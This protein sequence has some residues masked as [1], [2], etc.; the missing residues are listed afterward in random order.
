MT[1]TAIAFQRP[2]W[3]T[4]SRSR[5]ALAEHQAAIDAVEQGAL[6][7]KSAMDRAQA[8]V[9]EAEAA[10]RAADAEIAEINKAELAELVENARSGAPVSPKTQRT[11]ATA[12]ARAAECRRRV[13]VARQV[14][15]EVAVPFDEARSASLAMQ[16]Q[17]GQLACAVLAELHSDA[18]SRM[19]R[20][21]EEFVQAEIDVRSI[22]N[23]I[24]QEGRKLQ[25]SGR[26]GTPYY[27]AGAPLTQ[28]FADEPAYEGPRMPQLYRGEA[29]WSQFLL[30]LLGDADALP[31]EP[32]PRP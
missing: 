30:A 17:L 26:D 24:A 28:A 11:R 23:A 5:R 14:L 13:D 15:A 16:A 18:M 21:R 4:A 8:A 29:R 12:E 22:S 19:R 20:A 2:D 7:V 25:D 31:P 1:A 9:R 10:V 27:R 3:M 6:E 32:E